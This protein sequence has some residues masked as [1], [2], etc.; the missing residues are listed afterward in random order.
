[1][2]LFDIEEK[3]LPD[4]VLALLDEFV[5]CDRAKRAGQETQSIRVFR[6]K[7]VDALKVNGMTIGEVKRKTAWARLSK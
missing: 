5:N 6:K 2:G 4:E 7:V 3:K 1:M